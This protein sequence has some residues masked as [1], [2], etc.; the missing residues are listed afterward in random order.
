MDKTLPPCEQL[1]YLGLKMTPRVPRERRH[2]RLSLPPDRRLRLISHLDEILRI[3]SL[4]PAE[5]SS[6]GGCL[7]FYCWWA[8]EARSLLAEFAA[9]QYSRGYDYSLTEELRSA[10]QFFRTLL[11]AQDFLRG[12]RP[13]D[14]LQRKMCVIYAD[15]AL[16]GEGERSGFAYYPG[17]I[18]GIGGVLFDP[19]L[20]AP[21]HF[22]RPDLGTEFA[23]MWLIAPIEM[24]AIHVALE[25]FGPRIRGQ[26]G[27]THAIG[28]LLKGGNTISEASRK[29]T[30]G[31]VRAEHD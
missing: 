7:F 10:I 21:W 27:N 23:Y 6:Q 13:A 20:Q 16:E 2:F 15:G 25:L 26:A 31:E 28:C 18:R 22:A 24:H 29:R 12:V 30:R 3:S 5:A 1:I 17:A 19:P 9:R 8:P 4:T 11:H 14:I